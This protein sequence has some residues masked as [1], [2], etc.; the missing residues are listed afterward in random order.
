MN[1]QEV[2]KALQPAAGYRIIVVNPHT[3]LTHPQICVAVEH[4]PPNQRQT[5]D[6]GNVILWNGTIDLDDTLSGLTL[7]AREVESIEWYGPFAYIHTRKGKIVTITK[8]P[9]QEE[10]P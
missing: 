1:V 8:L 10:T 5:P 2:V 7:W 3:N 6:Q 9:P 4:L